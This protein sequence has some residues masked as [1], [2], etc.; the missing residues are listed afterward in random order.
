MKQKDYYAIL[1]VSRNASEDEIK[2]AYRRLALNYHPDK[3]PGDK[4]TEAKFRD[5]KDAY[6][7]LQ[8]VVERKRYDRLNP[9]EPG[10]DLEYHLEVSLKSGT[11]DKPGGC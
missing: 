2:K 5:A 6:E 4:T 3:N 10:R 1:N 9:P 7:L 11:D 8:D